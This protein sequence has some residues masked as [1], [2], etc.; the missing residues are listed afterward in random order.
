MLYAE[1]S[2]LGG[3]ELYAKLCAVDYHDDYHTVYSI[4]YHIWFT[5]L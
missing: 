4:V 5:L 3:I 2:H 1:L